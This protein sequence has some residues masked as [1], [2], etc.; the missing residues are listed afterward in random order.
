MEGMSAPFMMTPKTSK[1]PD[2]A[3]ETENRASE[4]EGTWSLVTW[5][6]TTKT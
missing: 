6:A 2:S 5:Y 1:N 3:A 4:T